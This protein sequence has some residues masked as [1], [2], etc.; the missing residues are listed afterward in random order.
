[1]F[2]S[3][4]TFFVFFAPSRVRWDRGINDIGDPATAP[5]VLCSSCN[6][7]T[8]TN[9]YCGI[10]ASSSSSSSSALK[11]PSSTVTRESCSSELVCSSAPN[12]QSQTVVTILHSFKLLKNLPLPQPTPLKTLIQE[13]FC[14]SPPT[15]SNKG[16]TFFHTCLQQSCKLFLQNCSSSYSA[17]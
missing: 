14:H 7:L 4:W 17:S 3:A 2:S 10:I 5:L 8:K 13:S 15:H 1:M 6:A 11:I 16:Y 9:L 12:Y